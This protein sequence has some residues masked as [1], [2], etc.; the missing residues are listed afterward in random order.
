MLNWKC[1]RGNIVGKLFGFKASEFL[2]T[3]EEEKAVPKV[4][5]NF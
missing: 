5:F 1:S 3:P 4:E 2:Q